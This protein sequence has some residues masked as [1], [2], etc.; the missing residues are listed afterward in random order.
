MT[1]RISEDRYKMKQTAD[2]YY[3]DLSECSCFHWES[4]RQVM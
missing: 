2:R 3:H 4:I 1:L